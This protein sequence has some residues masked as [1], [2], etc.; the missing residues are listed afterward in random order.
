MCLFLIFKYYKIKSILLVFVYTM[1]FRGKYYNLYL[2]MVMH[3]VF[4]I[5]NFMYFMKFKIYIYMVFIIY[6]HMTSGFLLINNASVNIHVC[7]N[8]LCYYVWKLYQFILSVELIRILTILWIPPVWT[9]LYCL[10]F[11][12]LCRNAFV[13]LYSAF[14][15]HKTAAKVT[16]FLSVRHV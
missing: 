7:E 10:S 3:V 2:A 11:W 15:Y 13:W 8:V 12:M 5:L 14:P 4:D 16:N 9:N 6:I 1:I